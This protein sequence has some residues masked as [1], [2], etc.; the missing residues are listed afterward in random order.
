MQHPTPLL[1]FELFAVPTPDANVRKGRVR[2]NAL[3]HFHDLPGHRVSHAH[4][5]HHYP[6]ATV[7]LI[8][9]SFHSD[10]GTHRLRD[11][12]QADEGSGQAVGRRA[13]DW[14]LDL[15]YQT[16]PPNPIHTSLARF[17]TV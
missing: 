4:L 6:I 3:H 16:H 10:N 14:D 12:A 7:D 5:P 11:L 1:L 13:S 17:V 2:G 8:T 9:P 15:P